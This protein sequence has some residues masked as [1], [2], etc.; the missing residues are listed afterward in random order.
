ML[1]A[2]MHKLVNCVS[3][4]SEKVYNYSREMLLVYSGLAFGSVW[5]PLQQTQ[6]CCMSMNSSTVI[7]TGI[8]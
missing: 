8:L 4:R 6:L 5:L 3:I 1:I 7:G 2:Y